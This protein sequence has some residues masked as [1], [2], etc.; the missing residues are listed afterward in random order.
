VI[1]VDYYEG[2]DALP[3]AKDCAAIHKAAFSASG[4]RGWTETEFKSLL[5]RH[6]TFLLKAQ[7]GFLLADLVVDEAEILTIAVAPDYQGQKI[8]RALMSNFDDICR[9]R[10]VNRCI[11]EVAEDNYAA[12]N[13]YHMFN[14]EQFTLREGYFKRENSLIS[15]LVMIRTTDPETK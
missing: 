2:P 15:A 1:H 13:L 7:Y 10:N 4:A 9:Y 11:L 3:H 12:K 8:G 5:E 14:F 6:S